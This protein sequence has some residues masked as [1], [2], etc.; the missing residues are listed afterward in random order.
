M[1]GPK[2]KAAPGVERVLFPG[3]IERRTMDRNLRDG[4]PVP[5]PVYDF[6]SR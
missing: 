4:I 5:K 6:L 1:T 2:G 3:E